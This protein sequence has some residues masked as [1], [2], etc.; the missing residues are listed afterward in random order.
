MAVIVSLGGGTR[1]MVFGTLTGGARGS[2]TTTSFAKPWG[3]SKSKTL[4]LPSDEPCARPGSLLVK[5]LGLLPA[6]P[7]DYTAKPSAA[8]LDLPTY[9][10]VGSVKSPI[11]SF[12]VCCL[13]LGMLF[14]FI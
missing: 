9:S 12:A 3:T 7:L 2:S 8:Y 6:L 1:K 11:D 10:A 14:I 13:M 5:P 4:L